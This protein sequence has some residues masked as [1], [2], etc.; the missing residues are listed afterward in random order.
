[1]GPR[2]TKILVLEEDQTRQSIHYLLLL[3]RWRLKE[4]SFLKRLQTTI[5]K[6]V[7]NISKFRCSGK[8][9][10]VLIWIVWQSVPR[11]I[12][13]IHQA[14]HSLGRWTHHVHRMMRQHYIILFS[15]K[16]LISQS[17]RS[18]DF[19]SIKNSQNDWKNKKK[20]FSFTS[21]GKRDV[22]LRVF[23]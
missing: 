12:I 14:W 10:K 13:L 3:A 9:R 21:K 11:W 2:T 22:C 19:T 20:Y 23:K 7:V 6:V 18:S 15:L 1:M 5:C 4:K 8:K 17:E 16:R